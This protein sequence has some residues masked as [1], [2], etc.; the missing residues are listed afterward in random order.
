MPQ[1]PLTLGYGA[2]IG[3]ESDKKKFNHSFSLF[4]HTLSLPITMQTLF[5]LS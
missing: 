2:M 4:F 3:L 5:F 1:L